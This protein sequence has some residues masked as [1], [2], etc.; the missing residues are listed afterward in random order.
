MM[1]ENTGILA[2]LQQGVQ[3][4]YALSQKIGAI[5]PSAGGT[6][7]TAVGGAITPPAQVVG[8]I[9]VTLPN[10]SAVKVPYYG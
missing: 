8:Y 6:S 9:V 4:I 5:F 2:T 7:G 1:M 3:A 10:G